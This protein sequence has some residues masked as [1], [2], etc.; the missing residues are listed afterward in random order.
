MRQELWAQSA[1]P[2]S[3]LTPFVFL[4]RSQLVCP[5]FTRCPWG[6]CTATERVFCRRTTRR[7]YRGTADTYVKTKRPASNLPN[8]LC[9]ELLF[10]STCSS[11][12][13]EEAFHSDNEDE[14]DQW[15]EK[16][17]NVAHCCHLLPCAEA[18]PSVLWEATK[19][20]WI[21]VELVLPVMT[22]QPV[23]SEVFGLEM[24]KIRLRT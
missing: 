1:K 16:K 10:I 8:S 6:E 2:L 11:F 21:H 20:K 22:H 9:Y 4:A 12:W 5:T 14:E 19:L 15:A 13:Q 24:N 23:I 7:G 3:Q 18:C 17:V